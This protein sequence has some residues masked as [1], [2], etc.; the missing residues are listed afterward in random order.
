MAAALASTEIFKTLATVV[1]EK[2]EISKKINAVYQFNVKGASGSAVWTVDLKNQV[3]KEGASS[4]AECTIDVSDDD[5]AGLTSQK[6]NA[7]TLFM[8]GKLKV[9]GNMMLAMKLETLFK[10]NT[11]SAATSKL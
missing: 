2:P 4:S 8:Q 1:K 7:Q 10:A 6:L 3:V 11:P 5:F 9:K